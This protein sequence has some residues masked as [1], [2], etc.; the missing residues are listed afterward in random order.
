MKH[1]VYFHARYVRFIPT[2][3]H[4]AISMRAGVYASPDE[5][6]AAGEPPNKKQK[7]EDAEFEKFQDKDILPG[8]DHSTMHSK[9][10]EEIKKECIRRGCEV[11]V[12][13]GT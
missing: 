3:W 7:T 8:Q 11:F 6:E 4:G 5:T 2:K 12:T 13:A 10:I 9:N 1:G